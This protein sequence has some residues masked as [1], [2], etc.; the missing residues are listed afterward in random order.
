MPELVSVII[1]TYNRA[2]WL[3]EALNSVLEQTYPNIELIV[4]N[5]GST[6]NTDE[7][8]QPYKDRLL[9]VK[10]ENSGCGAAVNTGVKLAKGEYITRL[11][12]DDQFLPDKVAM[13][14]EAFRQHPDVGLI[15]G[16][17]YLMDENGAITGTREVPDYTKHG[18][19]ITLLRHCIFAQPTVMVR[20]E[21][22]DKV[23]YYK[24]TYAQ[25]YDMWLRLARYY[26]VHVIN[27]PLAKYRVHRSN[28]SGNRAKMK[29][30]A[31]TIRNSV[32][33][34]LATIPLPEL[35]PALRNNGTP[36]SLARA[37]ATRSAIYMLHGAY[38][39]AESALQEARRLSPN[40]PIRCLWRGILERSKRNYAEAV[41][42]FRQVPEGNPFYPAAQKAIETT[43]RIQNFKRT[44]VHK[45]RQDV[46]RECAEFF[47]MTIAAIN[48]NHKSRV[49]NYELRGAP[50]AESAPRLKPSQYNIFAGDFPVAG[51]HLVYNTFTRASAVMGRKLKNIVDQPDQPIPQNAV[52]AVKKLHRMGIL[53]DAGIDE[54]EKIQGWYE[55]IRQN[56]L[57]QR[58]VVLTT[59]Q[60]NFACTYCIEGNGVV[61]QPIELD[62]EKSAKTANWIINRIRKTGAERVQMTFYGGEPLLNPDAIFYIAGELHEYAEKNGI[63]YEFSIS[64]NGSKL[65]PEL[66]DKLKP[67]GL[68]SMKITLDGDKEAHDA[69]RPF[70][71]GQGSFDTI[72]ENMEKVADKVIIGT[73]G[74][75]DERNIES[76]P[77]LFDVLAARE[78]QEKV[79]VDFSPIQPALK[80]GKTLPAMQECARTSSQS[81]AGII[82]KIIDLKSE[83]LQ[84]GFKTQIEPNYNICGMDMDGCLLVIDPLGR[85]Y[86]CPAFVGREG[87]EV[88]AIE[89]EDLTY[90]EN[91]KPRQVPQ[92]CLNC[93]FFPICGGGCRYGAYLEY[94]DSRRILCD[95]DYFEKLTNK[96]IKHLVEQQ[97]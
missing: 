93:K 58:F 1:P 48:T 14:V 65:T 70:R 38:E 18:V 61:H 27:Q 5:D 52:A 71:G 22:H 30:I 86:T 82:E 92:E 59:Y 24:N 51:K 67:L 6:D 75:L 85:I 4:V 50:T 80:G 29:V 23:G 81:Q 87:F 43:D 11:D 20:R 41:G 42:Y 63:T 2:Q 35:F 37:H 96:A 76:V 53:V 89:D 95:K 56:H 79:R 34:V 16:P 21:C 46:S 74:N 45:L 36:T 84:R 54:P 7:V 55:G 25:D 57:L 15:G 13:Q 19:F 66:V 47:D 90:D 44:D 3:I 10:Q 9:Y 32:C 68:V 62:A 69:Q 72:I 97:I 26:A 64:T 88:G 8:I 17:C 39:L 94:G 31:N 83:A 73:G 33:E 49:K 12:D 28:R 40:D 60:C 77:G 78:L 91:L